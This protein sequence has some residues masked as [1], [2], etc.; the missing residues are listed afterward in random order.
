N[1][2]WFWDFGNGD[3]GNQGVHQMDVARWM[4]PDATLP[5]HVISLGGRFGYTDQGETPNSQISIFDYGATQLIFEVRGLKTD[6]YQKEK[7]GNVL[8]FEEGIVAGDKFYPR[9]KDQAEPLPKFEA[10]EKRG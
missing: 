3:I 9:G 1:W 10:S 8:H 4:I 7:I 6:G 5:R 2:H